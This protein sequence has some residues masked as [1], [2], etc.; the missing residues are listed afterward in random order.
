MYV[1]EPDSTSLHL[2]YSVYLLLSISGAF[3]AIGMKIAKK[4][5]NSILTRAKLEG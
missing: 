1:I 4:N 3:S 2:T 5:P